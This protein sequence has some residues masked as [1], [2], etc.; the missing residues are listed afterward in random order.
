MLNTGLSLIINILTCHIL[1]FINCIYSYKFLIR[2]LTSENYKIGMIP[3]Q[4]GDYQS[5]NL[6]FAKCCSIFLP[7]Y[8]AANFTPFYFVR[9]YII[10]VVQFTFIIKKVQF[11]DYALF[12][13]YMQIIIYIL[14]LP[15]Y[16]FKKT[17]LLAIFFYYYYQE[18][19]VWSISSYVS[20]WKF[21]LQEREPC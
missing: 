15:I 16:Y 2:P 18:D 14:L 9:M 7:F 13:T 8:T 3:Q 6:M 20:D 21:F 5:G 10:C 17:G 4:L 12:I 1:L 11:M 19:I